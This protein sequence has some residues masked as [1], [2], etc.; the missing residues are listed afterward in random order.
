MY[1][2]LEYCGL[3]LVKPITDQSNILL[4]CHSFYMTK[5]LGSGH[6]KICDKNVRNRSSPRKVKIERLS[7]AHCLRLISVNVLN[8]NI[9]DVIVFCVWKTSRNSFF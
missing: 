9:G 7:R 3:V 2:L 6:N 5:E 1:V 4:P 8:I